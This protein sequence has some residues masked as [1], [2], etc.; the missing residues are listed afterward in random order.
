MARLEEVPLQA[1]NP[2]Q[3]G[4]IAGSTAPATTTRPLRRHYSPVLAHYSVDN[5][6]RHHPEKVEDQPPRL[7]EQNSASKAAE[8]FTELLRSSLRTIVRT[9]I[10]TNARAAKVKLSPS[11]SMVIG[12]S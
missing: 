1:H 9:A 7:Q 2:A 12:W 4:G 5:R 3:V 10:R 11:P 8:K 6:P